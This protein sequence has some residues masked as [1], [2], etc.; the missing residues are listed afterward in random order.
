M[1]LKML[2]LS[3]VAVLWQLY[4][5]SFFLHG[6]LPS[7]AI[8]FSSTLNPKP[9]TLNPIMGIMGLSQDC[10]L[11]PDPLEALNL[12]PQTLNPRPPQTLA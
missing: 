9:Q 2:V 1:V 8:G 5:F 7:Y 10:K 3:P 11:S 6:G 4:C 12:K